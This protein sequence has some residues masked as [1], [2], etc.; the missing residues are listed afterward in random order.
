MMFVGFGISFWYRFALILFY[1]WIQAQLKFWFDFRSGSEVDFGSFRG[2]LQPQKHWL[3]LE[4]TASLDA[5]NGALAAKGPAGCVKRLKQLG[6]MRAQLEDLREQQHE[7][8]NEQRE[9]IREQLE[10][11]R[12]QLEDI[13]EHH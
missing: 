4:T 11:I 1:V 8:I 6:D 5:S 2:S 10:D 9:Y 12:E 3:S 13:R 7:D